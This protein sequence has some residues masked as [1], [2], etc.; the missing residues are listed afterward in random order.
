MKGERADCPVLPFSRSPVPV[1]CSL[2]PFT[3][4]GSPF[5]SVLRPS[6]SSTLPAFCTAV[7][8]LVAPALRER[9]VAVAA[10]GADRATILALSAEAKAAG[11]T[12]GMPVA[13][14]KKLCPDLILR[15]PNPRLY[16][17]ASRALFEILRRYAPVIEPKRIRPCLSRHDRHQQAVRS[18]GGCGAED[19]AGIEPAHRTDLAVGA[20]ANKLVSRTASEVVKGL[21]ARAAEPPSRRV[22]H[23][24]S[25]L[26]GS[27]AP[28][29]APHPTGLLPDLP[30][31]MRERLDDYQLEL[32]GEVAALEQQQ[33][34]SVFGTPGRVLHQHARGIDPRPVMA[35]E[36]KAEFRAAHTLASDT[37]DLGLIHPLLRHLTER[38]GQRLRQRQLVSR[39]LTLQLAYTDYATAKRSISLPLAALDVELW[40]AAR[41]AFALANSRTVA[42]RALGISVDRLVEA[43]LQLEL[44]EIGRRKT[45]DGRWETGDGEAGPPQLHVSLRRISP[46]RRTAEPP[47]LSSPPSTRSAPAGATGDR[48]GSDAEPVKALRLTLPVELEL[49]MIHPDIARV[50]HRQLVLGGETT[51]QHDDRLLELRVLL[52][53][54]GKRSSAVLGA[55]VCQRFADLMEL[56]LIAA[57][58]MAVVMDHLVQIP[59]CSLVPLEV[60]ASLAGVTFHGRNSRRSNRDQERI[61]HLGRRNPGDPE[62][63]SSDQNESITGRHNALRFSLTGSDS[64][65]L[66]RVANGAPWAGGRTHSINRDS[67]DRNGPVTPFCS[68]QSCLADRVSQKAVKSERRTVNGSRLTSYVSRLT[69]HD[70]IPT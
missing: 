4:H 27:E 66:R 69:S 56:M 2:F 52:L 18:G 31:E 51:L 5:T 23:F 9:P 67:G 24:S 48:D 16:A 54:R 68:G 41:R 37:N 20:A 50:L 3:V 57:Q 64:G 28:F 12:R 61:S 33:L 30:E 35:P 42:I 60:T 15:A 46:N 1:L 19:P 49:M 13:K 43:D 6:S 32:I 14:A 26:A 38:L 10:P 63:E 17:R 8:G 47:N 21:V 62:S 36:V 7:E 39:R 22:R 58:R 45:G 25:I 70:V 59:L 29:L 55:V 40:D 53:V 44:W 65:L 34:Y 11:I